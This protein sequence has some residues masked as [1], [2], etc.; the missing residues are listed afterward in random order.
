MT[1]GNGGHQTWITAPKPLV[2]PMTKCSNQLSDT[3]IAK[4][5]PSPESQFGVTRTVLIFGHE[6][7]R[8]TRELIELIVKY[9]KDYEFHFDNI[10]LTRLRMWVSHQQ[11]NWS[12]CM[13]AFDAAQM[14]LPHEST[15]LQPHEILFGSEMRV[16]FDWRNA[17]DLHALRKDLPKTELEVRKEAQEVAKRVEERIAIAR[18]NI[19]AAQERQVRQANKARREPDF[20]VGDRVFIVKKVYRTDRPSRKLDFPLTQQ[21]YEIESRDGDTFT[22]KVPSH[23]RGSPIYHSN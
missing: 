4:R 6:S 23:W 17:T 13:S 3:S 5:N 14:S 9:C 22:L 12:R 2:K 16:S 10:I 18:Q 1:E 8:N 19:T 11:D 21:H 15:G 20:D 7:T